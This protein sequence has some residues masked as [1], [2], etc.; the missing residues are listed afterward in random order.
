MRLPRSCKL[1][2]VRV[3]MT[4]LAN[5]WSFLE[6]HV[7]QIDFHVGWAMA[8]IALHRS[9]R[10]GKHE[11]CAGMVELADVFPVFCV[12]AGFASTRAATC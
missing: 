4:V 12:V 6:V 8:A 3:L 1:L 7:P 10:A 5:L 9:V 2:S 11:L